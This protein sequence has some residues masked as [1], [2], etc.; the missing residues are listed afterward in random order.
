MRQD[1]GPEEGATSLSGWGRTAPTRARVESPTT[2]LEVVAAVHEAAR[3]TRRRGVVAR[4]LGRSYGDAAQNAGGAVLDLT[5]LAQVHRLDLE[6]GVVEVDA[7][8]SLDRLLRVVLP[9]GLTL[10]VQPGTRQVT[11]GGAVACDVHGKNHHTAGSFGRYVRSLVLLTGAGDAIRLKP[12]GPDP[13]LFWGTVG[14]MGLTG[15][16]LRVELELRRVET[17][18]VVVRAERQPDLH[19]VMDALREHDRTAEYSV[20]WF[21]SLAQGAA[22]GRGV[23]M[24]G[25]DAVRDDLTAAQREDP[26]HVPASRRVQVPHTP[27]CAVNG[28]SGRAFNEAYFRRAPRRPSTRVEHA[29]GFFQPLDGL[30]SWNRLYG[31]RGLVQYQLVIP[32]AAS[33]VVVEVVREVAASGH[34]SCLNVLKRFGPGTPGLLSFPAPG[35][36]L[37]LDLPVRAGLD[38]VLDR[39]DARVAEAGGRLYLAKDSR[40]PRR[41]L[42]TMYPRLGEFAELRHR[43]DP[44][45]LFVSDLARRLGLHRPTEGNLHDA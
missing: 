30:Q 24:T 28:V 18:R 20:A 5:G 27:L 8:I 3:E 9:L 44:G 13:E 16:V 41:H 19:G 1:R 35:W 21:D 33:E 6:A 15:V 31:P 10:P 4:G 26:L 32:D 38:A 29:F 22:T 17:S 14:G 42:P 40:L 11:V 34:V 45:G 7:G 39:L 25:R 37:A 36:T 23:V 12:R 2:D 43:A